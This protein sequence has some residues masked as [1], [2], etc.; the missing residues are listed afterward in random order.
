MYSNE[1]NF[2]KRKDV[3]SSK[4]D[5]EIILLDTTQ[6]EYLRFS[7]VAARALELLENR[8]KFE[9]LCETIFDEFEVDRDRCQRYV[10][11]SKRSRYSKY[12]RSRLISG[13]TEPRSKDF[14]GGFQV[15]S[16]PRPCI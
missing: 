2:V 1:T 10:C 6:G 4:V 9:T 14:S 8:T 11:V 7:N 5:D 3:I 15:R 12:C 13:L 16:G